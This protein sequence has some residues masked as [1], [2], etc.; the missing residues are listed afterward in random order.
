MCLFTSENLYSYRSGHYEMRIISIS[1]I[2]KP[3]S[4]DSRQP[5]RSVPEGGSFFDVPLVLETLIS[6]HSH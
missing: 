5:P 2:Q 3:L 1:N 4:W 6:L